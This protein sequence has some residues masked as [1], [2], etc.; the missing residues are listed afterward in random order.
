[1]KTN[2]QDPAKWMS[3]W[4]EKYNAPAGLSLLDQA[5]FYIVRSAF[6]KGSFQGTFAPMQLIR[7][8]ADVIRD[9]R[10][11]PN[12]SRCNENPVALAL[13]MI[14]NAP[15]PMDSAAAEI[16]ATYLSVSFESRL[17]AISG[18]LRFN[19]EWEPGAKERIMKKFPDDERFNKKWINKVSVAYDLAIR[20]DKDPRAEHL[21]DLD[22]RIAAEVQSEPYCNLGQR[23]E[24]LR[25]PTAHGNTWG[26]GSE[27][28]FYGLLMIVLTLSDPAWPTMA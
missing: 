8:C 4:Y 9:T 22:K 27:A 16:A 18:V 25:D 28:Y 12:P 11:A 26:T 7:H 3:D 1:M 23:I 19:G 21:R 14:A 5:K 15:S 13:S 2:E 24:D 17:R 6:R 20:N 10:G